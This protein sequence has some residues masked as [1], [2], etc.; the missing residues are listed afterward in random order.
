MAGS[1]RRSYSKCTGSEISLWCDVSQGGRKKIS[2]LGGS[3]GKILY[4]VFMK[5]YLKSMLTNTV[6]HN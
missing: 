5:T 2:E 3:K 1:T 4:K 6:N